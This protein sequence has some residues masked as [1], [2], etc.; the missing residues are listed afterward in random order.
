MT[1]DP[2]VLPS[3]DLIASDDEDSLLG[4]WSK[5]SDVGRKMSNEKQ[6]EKQGQRLEGRRTAGWEIHLA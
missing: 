3:D 4:K 1:I 2:I 5:I 6:W